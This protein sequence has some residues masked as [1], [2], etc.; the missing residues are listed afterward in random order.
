M[1]FVVVD[2][3]VCCRFALAGGWPMGSCLSQYEPA[4]QA[5]YL[6]DSVLLWSAAALLALVP[7]LAPQVLPWRAFSALVSLAAA[8]AQVL[9]TAVL[10]RH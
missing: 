2:F 8:A 5:A 9:R 6:S 3:L 4:E 10:P 1:L 7:V